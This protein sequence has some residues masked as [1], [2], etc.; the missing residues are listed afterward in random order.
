MGYLGHSIMVH[1][2]I[3][4]ADFQLLQKSVCLQRKNCYRQT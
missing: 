2:D 1:L 3:T 4:T